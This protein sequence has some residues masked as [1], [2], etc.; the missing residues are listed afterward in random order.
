MKIK[1]TLIRN[2][3][4]NWL[5]YAIQIAVVFYTSPKLV[6]TLGEDRYGVWSLVEGVIGYFAILDFGLSSTVVRFVAKYHA[7]NEW[8]RLNRL[9]S[10]SVLILGVCSLIVVVGACSIA[11]GFEDPF[12][13]NDSEAANNARWLLVICGLNLAV[14]FATQAYGG[15]LIGMSKFPTYNGLKT[16]GV[17]GWAVAV[18]VMLDRGYG[19]VELVAVKA[20]IDCFA[21]VLM[22]W[23]A[24]RLLPQCRLD[25]TDINRETIDDVRSFSGSAFLIMMAGAAASHSD[26][27]FIAYFL[28]L[29]Y[30]TY[31]MIAKRLAE[32]S[33]SFFQRLYTVLTPV[34]SS[35][36][37]KNENDKICGILLTAT[38][39]M[40]YLAVPL[41]AGLIYLGKPFITLW[42][43]AD[44]AAFSYPVLVILCMPLAFRV[45]QS[46]ASKVLYGT[47]R[48][49][50]LTLVAI[51]QSVLNVVVSIVLIP[52]YGIIG[53]A[54]GT[55]LPSIA[56]SL[57]MC[58]YTCRRYSISP[59]TYVGATLLKPC[60][61]L[62]AMLAV[63]YGVSRYYP[64]NSW[65]AFLIVGASGTVVYA[66][67][68]AIIEFGLYDAFRK[69]Q[70]RFVP[71]A[72]KPEFDANS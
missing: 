51:A 63:W 48:L 23:R 16:F 69:L 30:V 41:Q 39:Y 50:W 31:Y 33:R 56:A 8:Q 54:L 3:F 24:K 11:F 35:L 47:G 19:L 28:G 5:A 22:V 42:M 13:L 72:R 20:C 38:R 17:L 67:A 7:Q 12:H 61:P 59:F 15:I 68:A 64:V 44:L 18:V 45:T 66:L 6:H 37:A 26:A 29:R 58:G 34:F 14:T 62:P 25:F 10:A 32:Y 49:K 57:V 43:D 21:Q 1:E 40:L 36:D 2:A 27:V 52:H 71:L 46:V 70:A 55:T 53:C 65:L 9:I 4:S 60:I